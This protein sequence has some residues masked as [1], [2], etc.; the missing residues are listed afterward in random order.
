VTVITISCANSL[1][2][3]AYANYVMLIMLINWIMLIRC[4]GINPALA[5][6]NKSISFHD[7]LS[8]LVLSRCHLLYGITQCY[9]PTDTSEHIPP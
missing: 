3:L 5:Y 8:Q 9:L 1:S 4:W 6:I 7:L 2:S